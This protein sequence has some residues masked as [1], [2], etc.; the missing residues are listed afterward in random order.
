M[1]SVF[2]IINK[3]HLSTSYPLGALQSSLKTN[4]YNS[5]QVA[6]QE[7]VKKLVEEV[8]NPNADQW[9]KDKIFPAKEVYKKF[10]EAGFLGIHRPTE[11]GGQGLSYKYNVAFIEAL[12]YSKSAGAAMA[13]GVHTD[14]TTPALV[15]FGSEKLK[16]TY[17]APAIAGD[18]VTSLAVSEPGGGSDVAA[19]KT[20]AV[21]SGDDLVINGSKMWITS[22]MQ[23]DWACLL[24]NTEKDGGKWFNKSLIIVPMDS[25][26]ISKS[27]ISKM[28]MH[29]SDTAILTFDNVHVPADH[30]V[31]DPGMGFVYQMK[32]FQ[33][34]RMVAAVGTLVPL[35]LIIEETLEYCKQ[36]NAFGKPLI[37][38][39]YIQYKLAELYTEVEMIRAAVYITADNIEK[40]EDMTMM[41]S[42]L[43]LKVGRLAREVTDTCLQFWGGMGFTEDVMVSKAYRD[44]R[45]G[46]IAGGADEIML[47]IICKLADMMPSKKK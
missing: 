38:N 34:E 32:Q 35:T 36:R 20:T 11:Y 29:A 27:M 28:G 44:L 1:K 25:K 37:S 23:S 17:L 30:I 39:Q 14:C 16:E 45:L 18:M 4:F 9:D 7:S 22:G 3:R 40:E 33:D 46:S 6:L 13:I 10:G 2:Q 41:C 42:M 15:N 19:I 21:K 47:G 5:E 26:G 12:G 24:A 8:I 43:K 31:G